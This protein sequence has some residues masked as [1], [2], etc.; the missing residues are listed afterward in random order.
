MKLWPQQYSLRDRELLDKTRCVCYTINTG[1]TEYYMTTKYALKNGAVLLQTLMMTMT[2]SLMATMVLKWVLNRYAL[3]SAVQGGAIRTSLADGYTAAMLS[4]GN[5]PNN[6][7]FVDA[8]SGKRI[9]FRR[10]GAGEYTTTV[11]D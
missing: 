5:P 6:S 8:N 1:C 4:G 9:T 10:T 3:A 7:S 11:S 2:I